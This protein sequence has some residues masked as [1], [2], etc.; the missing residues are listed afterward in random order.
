M[1]RQT[2]FDFPGIVYITAAL[3]GILLFLI[4]GESLVGIKP[5]LIWIAGI[6]GFLFALG[7]L[8]TWLHRRNR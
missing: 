8:W 7:V 4:F 2:R 1:N 3:V 5:N 6:S